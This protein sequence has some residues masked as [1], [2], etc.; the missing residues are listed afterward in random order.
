MINRLR[1]I[2]AAASLVVLG[3][4]VIASQ[5]SA[6]LRSPQVP[7]VGGGLQAYLNVVNPGINVNTD[8]QDAQT[9]QQS[10]SG[11]ASVTVMFQ[12]SP[13]AAIQQVGIYNG[14]AVIPPLF[15]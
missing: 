13:N 10:V 8:Q 11:N 14:G 1:T 3:S 9:F 4:A 7:V 15:F 12:S 2:V 5:A 6:G